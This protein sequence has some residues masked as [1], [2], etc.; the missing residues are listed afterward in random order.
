MRFL[1]IDPA[2]KT[3]TPVEAEGPHEAVPKLTKLNVDHGVVH[4]N[5]ERGIGIIVYEYGLC[6]G[7]GPYFELMGVLY[8]GDA[9]L[10][11]FDA[12]GDT[13]DMRPDEDSLITPLWLADK[14]EV[15]LAIVAGLVARPQSSVNGAVIWEW[16]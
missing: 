2:A 5:R 13:I 11:G 12:P 7:E 1:H 8:S 3:V 6:E 10:Y 16:S 9:V 4:Q 14:G 15:E